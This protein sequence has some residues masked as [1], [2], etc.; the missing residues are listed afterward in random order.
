M[1]KTLLWAFVVVNMTISLLAYV[2]DVEYINENVTM[3]W[4]VICVLGICES[5]EKVGK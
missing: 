5:I 4:I 2:N 1:A 3:F